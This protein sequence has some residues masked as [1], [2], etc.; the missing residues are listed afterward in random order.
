MLTHLT[1]L[2]SLV[3]T[4]L[5]LSLPMLT[6]AELMGILSEGG[7]MAELMGILSEGGSMAEQLT[8]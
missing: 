8:S 3:L 7:S 1:L 5:T 4:C 2:L 6:M